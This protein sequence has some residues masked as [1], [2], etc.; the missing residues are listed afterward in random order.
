MTQILQPIE[1][2]FRLVAEDFTV[3]GTPD[4]NSKKQHNTIVEAF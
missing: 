4:N 3:L 2:L 1:Q